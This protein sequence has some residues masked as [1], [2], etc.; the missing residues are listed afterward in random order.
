[1][2]EGRTEIIGKGRG[3]MG[4]DRANEGRD[5]GRE[6]GIT[7]SQG[8]KEKGGKYNKGY[9]TLPTANLR[10]PDVFKLCN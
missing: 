8:E 2:M 4:G 9:Y 3:E 6:G 7:G 1:M 5:D 10:A